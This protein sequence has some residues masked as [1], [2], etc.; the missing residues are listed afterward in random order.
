MNKSR[1]VGL[2]LFPEFEPLDVFGPVEA[3]TVAHFS[4]RDDDDPPYPFQ[5]VSVAEKDT[6]VVMRG[7][8]RVVPDHTFAH[9]PKLDI[10][11]APGG[12]GTR[13]QYKNETLHAFVRAQAQRTEIIASVCTGAALLGSAGLLDGVR[14]T[15]NRRAFFWV[16]SVV[17]GAV[18]DQSARWVDSGNIVTSAG[19]SAG[20]DM[21]LHL[22][23]RLLGS[24]V[25]RAAASRME[26]V[27]NPDPAYAS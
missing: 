2:L 7:G 4:G 26:Y 5:V 24:E 23:A 18:W 6:P 19:I 22:V 14:A 8:M 15:T 13:T 3:L 20:T 9:C 1:R 10:L 16:Q 27:W 12:F 11:I 17:P 25:A 21:T